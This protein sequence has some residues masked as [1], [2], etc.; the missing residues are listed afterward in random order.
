MLFEREILV[1]TY[2]LPKGNLVRSSVQLYFMCRHFKFCS[3][4]KFMTAIFKS[5][6]QN[7]SPLHTRLKVKSTDLAISW[8]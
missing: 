6:L 5:D 7:I 3:G 4:E 1:T 8:T 2:K